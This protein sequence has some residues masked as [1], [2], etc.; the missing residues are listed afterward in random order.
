MDNDNEFRSHAR[1]S[2]DNDN[3]FRS[4][5]Y[6]LYMDNDNEFRS[7]NDN[8]FRSHVTE[9]ELDTLGLQTMFHHKNCGNP[10]GFLKKIEK[11]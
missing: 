11:K 9:Y 3:V 6:V 8:E 2:M 10:G 5:K 1:V 4:H 7:H